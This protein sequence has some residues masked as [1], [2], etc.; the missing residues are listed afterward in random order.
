MALY[1]EAVPTPTP[2]TTT[3]TRDGQEQ[4]HHVRRSRR[5]RTRNTGRY[6][7]LFSQR[8]ETDILLEILDFIMEQ[9]KSMSGTLDSSRLQHNARYMRDGMTT[10]TMTSKLKLAANTSNK[11]LKKYLDKLF[12][13]EFIRVD[14]IPIKRRKGVAA[15]KSKL[16]EMRLTVTDK[17]MEF[18][19]LGHEL[20]SFIKS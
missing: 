1:I 17:G 3:T 18:R 19:R 14:E 15:S 5:S 6:N 13:H 10:F 12:R 2:T 20:Q 11:Q 8:D 7:M 9:D 16:K 4:Q